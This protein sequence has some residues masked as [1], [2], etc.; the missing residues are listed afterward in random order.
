MCTVILC[1]S[2]IVKK[3]LKDKMSKDDWIFLA[4]S[5]SIDTSWIGFA[6][7]IF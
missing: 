7:G 6:L 3:Q 5:L 1:I 2:W 4:C